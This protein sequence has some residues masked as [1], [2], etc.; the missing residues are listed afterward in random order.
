MVTGF[1]VWVF[2]FQGLG[3]N[4]TSTVRKM[5]PTAHANMTKVMILHSLVVQ[6]EV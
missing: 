6:G 4:W 3:N 5:V 1:R 2:R